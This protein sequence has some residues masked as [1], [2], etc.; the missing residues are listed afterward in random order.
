VLDAAL[1]ELV[2]LLDE[3]GRLAAEHVATPRRGLSVPARPQHARIRAHGEDRRGRAAALAT[4]LRDLVHAGAQLGRR[5]VDGVPGRADL[6]SAAQRRAAVAADPERWMGLLQGLGLE[7]QVVELR[8]AAPERRRPLR[9]QLDHRA[10]VLVGHRA[11][12]GEGHAEHPALGLDPAGAHAEDHAPAAQRVER[13]DHLGGDDRLAVRHDQHRR[14]ELHAMGGAGQHAERHQRVED[15][16]A[17]VDDVGA[18][19]DDVIAHPHRVIAE[20]LGAHGGAADE[21]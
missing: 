13:R 14:S 1:A 9:P 11:A 17:E 19:D 2:D 6:G 12:L 7:E 16:L 10:Q 15:R 20:G 3:R 21:I 8:V 18:G 5:A 4:A